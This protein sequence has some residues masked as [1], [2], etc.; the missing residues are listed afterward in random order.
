MREAFEENRNITGSEFVGTPMG[1]FGRTM[2]LAFILFPL[3]IITFGLTFAYG[4][5]IL[6]RYIVNNTIIGGRRLKLEANFVELWLK[7]IVWML[8]IIVTFGL[9]AFLGFYFVARQK[10]FT[11][12]KSFAN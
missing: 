8:L 3:G 11:K 10:W 4:S 7:S 6:H 1:Y 2:L 9:Y 12:H 5:L